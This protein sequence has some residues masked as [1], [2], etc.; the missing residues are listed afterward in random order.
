MREQHTS[1]LPPQRGVVLPGPNLGDTFENLLR[2]R[3][4]GKMTH[5]LKECALVALCNQSQLE[6]LHKSLTHSL[7]DAFLG[8]ELAETT[9]SYGDLHSKCQITT[10]F[11]GGLVDPLPP[12]LSDL[13]LNDPGDSSC[14]NGVPFLSCLR[15]QA[16][17]KFQPKIW[18]VLL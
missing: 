2:H 5:V 16:L 9:I 12:F 14:A 6:P 17:Q 4:V 8:L 7:K 13:L 11:V 3:A 18:V 1:Q 10:R 15:Y